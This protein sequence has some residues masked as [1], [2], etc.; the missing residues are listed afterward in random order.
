MSKLSYKDPVLP[1]HFQGLSGC[2]S[3]GSGS[4]SPLLW[5]AAASSLEPMGGDAHTESGLHLPPHH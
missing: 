1:E 5:A 4:H 2:H 3:L